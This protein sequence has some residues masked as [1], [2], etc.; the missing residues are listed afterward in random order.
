MGLGGQSKVWTEPF[1]LVT[2]LGGQSSGGKIWF[3]WHA[4]GTGG[5]AESV[6]AMAAPVI[7]FSGMAKHEAKILSS[8]AESGVRISCFG[9]AFTSMGTWH[10][11]P[12]GLAEL[13]ATMLELL[14]G[15]GDQARFVAETRTCAVV[16]LAT[17]WTF[18]NF[19][20]GK[21]SSRLSPN[22]AAWRCRFM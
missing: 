3:R 15:C 20:F 14:T 10:V 11:H 8:V 5:R 12:G 6:G 7:G 21:T 2:E 1:A 17:V 22:G 16:S 19:M 18:S 9:G 4:V 13:V